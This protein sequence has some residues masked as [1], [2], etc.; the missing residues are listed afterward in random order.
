MIE[1]TEN[2]EPRKAGRPSLSESDKE[3]RLDFVIHRLRMGISTLEIQKQFAQK[4]NYSSKTAKKWVDLAFESIAQNNHRKRRHLH[5]MVVEMMHS[6]LTGY[7]N[8]LVAMQGQIQ[9]QLELATE[10]MVLMSQLPHLKG[11]SYS[12]TQQRV[13]DIEV[14]PAGICDLIEKK[15]RV[16]ERMARTM[17]ELCR[18]QGLYSGASDWRNAVSTLLDNDMLPAPIASNILNSIEEFESQNNKTPEIDLLDSN[19]ALNSGDIASAI[20]A[21]T[22]ATDESEELPPEFDLLL[23]A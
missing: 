23:E 22:A 20:H 11:M 21:A 6:Q 13:K 3:A 4:F 12:E 2:Q 10:W 16:R 9:S 17:V 14:T 5:A 15:S 18:I 19:E 8:D 1:P 7:Q